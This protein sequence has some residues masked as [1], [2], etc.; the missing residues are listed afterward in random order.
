M[1]AFPLISLFITRNMLFRKSVRIKDGGAAIFTRSGSTSHYLYCLIENLRKRTLQLQ[2]CKAATQGG[3][4]G[5]FIAQNKILGDIL[6]LWAIKFV[7]KNA[8]KAQ[9]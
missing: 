2:L 6:V 1:T 4:M 9:I 7:N 5:D 3:Q 8:K